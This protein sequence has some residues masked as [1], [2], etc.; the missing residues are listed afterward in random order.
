M[1]S[2]YMQ[3]TSYAYN[4]IRTWQFNKQ[5]TSFKYILLQR[6]LSTEFGHGNLMNNR[7]V[8]HKCELKRMRSIELGR[9]YTPKWQH[10]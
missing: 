7:P 1:P 10:Q 2:T 5:H 6:M 4:I 8:S 9:L 3:S